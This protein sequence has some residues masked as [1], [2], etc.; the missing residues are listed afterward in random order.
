MTFVEIAKPTI[1][2]RILIMI[3]QAIFYNVYFFLYI[4]SPIT[5][6][7]V[8]G[9]FEEEAVMSYTHYLEEIDSGRLENVPAPDIAISYWR[10]KSDARLREVV[11]AVRDDEVGHRDRNHQFAD[12][13]IGNESR[14]QNPSNPM[15]Q[16]S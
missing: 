2:E 16:T 10:L 5:A 9:Y 8:V 11:L 13:L 14:V 1:F 6:H 4:I 3:V 7:R 12:A 15:E